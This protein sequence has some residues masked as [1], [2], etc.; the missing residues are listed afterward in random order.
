M[1]MNNEWIQPLYLE[2]HTS[3]RLRFRRLNDGDVK[4][5]WEFLNQPEAI[6]YLFIDV[7]LEEYCT[8]WFERQYNRYKTG[9]MGLCAIE[10]KA[11]GEFVGQCGLL[12]QVVDEQEELEIGYHFLPCYWGNGYATE[13]AR[14][15]KDFAFSNHL[16]ESIISLIHIDNVR[17][18]KVAL[19]N[20]MKVDKRSLFHTLPVDIYRITRAEWEKEKVQ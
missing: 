15:C 10:L 6:R 19:R 13:A 20:G 16:A 9:R 14:A 7:T 11:S 18:Q 5:H 12:P 2:N 4:Y 17:S 1:P 3:Q 8:R